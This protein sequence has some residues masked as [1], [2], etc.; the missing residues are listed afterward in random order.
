ML[1]YLDNAATSY[2]KPT[3]VTD[4]NRYAM[5]NFTTPH[6]AMHSFGQKTSRALEETRESIAGFFNIED[7]TRLI[8]TPSCTYALNFVLK[9]IDWQQNDT[10]VIS[11]LEHNATFIPLMTLKEKFSL[12]IHTVPYAQYKG[13]EP[14]DLERLLIKYKV[15]LIVLPHASNVTGE[16][17]PL[18]KVMTLAEKYNTKVLVDGTQAVGNFA[19]DLQELGVDYYA[20]GGHKYLLG[21]PGVGLLYVKDDNTLFPLVEGGTGYNTTQEEMPEKLPE[22]LEP[23]TLNLPAIWALNSAVS[24]IR[25]EGLENIYN[26]K[27]ELVLIAV[28][29]FQRIDKV[30]VY[31]S[32]RNNVGIVSFNIKGCLPQE[33]ASILDKKYNI[34]VRAGLHCAPQAHKVAGTYPGG[35]VRISFSCFND[36]DDLKY[37]I[38]AVKE[39]SES[40]EKG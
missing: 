12:D 32:T 17:L 34:C 19:I 14:Y 7:C 37:L 33:V 30:E 40:L 22:R 26:A 20:F 4:A 35:S 13:F 1:I 28:E 23:G 2:P 27:R 16:I 3:T 10:V 39:I 38:K 29:N 31:S 5:L 36:K 15:K 6:R 21:P 8:F 11:S 25:S 18:R 24:Y 9:G